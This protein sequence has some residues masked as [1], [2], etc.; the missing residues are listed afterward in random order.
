MIPDEL[1]ATAPSSAPAFVP[2]PTGERFM[3]AVANGP[4]TEMRVLLLEGPRGEGKTTD[5]IYAV[6]ELSDRL[7][8]EGREIFLPVKVAVVRDTW[9]SLERT[10]LRSFEEQRVR[11]LPVVF[12]NGRREAK[13]EFDVPLVEFFFF[14]LDRPEDADKFQGFSCGVL[15]IEEPAPAAGL[16]AGVPIE[17]IAIGATSVRQ[18]GVPPRILLTMNPPDSDSW[19]IKVEERLR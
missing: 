14:G 19:T 16:T 2:S 10:T 11:G 18:P 5:A 13:I 7:R 4:P 15:W 17:S 12:T 3:A 1:L 6:L 8:R 9:V